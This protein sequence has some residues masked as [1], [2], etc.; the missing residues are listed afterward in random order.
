M[1]IGLVRHFPV[2][3]QLP[4][5][6]KSAAELHAWRLRY[7][8]SPAIVGPADVG[9]VPWSRCV[10]SDMERA[11]VTAR[12]VFSGPIE[13]MPLLREAEIE[14]FRTGRMRLPMWAWRWIMRFAWLTGHGSQR[15]GRD[16]FR[17]RVTEAAE[18]LE[19]ADRAGGGD[20]LVVSHAGTMA[21]LSAELRRRGY[22]GPRLRVAHHATL[23]V[24]RKHRDRE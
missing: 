14:Q 6:W 13:R 16:A 12:A 10:S 7:D 24:Y 11:L 21:Y 20:I 5:G 9:P 17:R 15:A 2:E 23:Y 4:R 19:A 22:V 1:R 18:F 3:Q 8:E